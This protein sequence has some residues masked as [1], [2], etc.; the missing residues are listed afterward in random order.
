MF[1]RPSFIMKTTHTAGL[2]HALPAAALRDRPTASGR[3]ALGWSSFAVAAV[4]VGY[5]LSSLVKRSFSRTFDR[6]LARAFAEDT[7]WL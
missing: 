3:A 1:T 4:G 5:L 6:S 7:N 2:L